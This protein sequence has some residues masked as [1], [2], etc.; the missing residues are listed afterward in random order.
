MAVTPPPA[1]VDEAA[2]RLGESVDPGWTAVRATVITAVRRTARRSWPVAADVGDLPGAGAGPVH[3]VDQVLRAALA[4]GVAADQACSVQWARLDVE[5][6][7]L[8]GV[9]LG[10]VAGYGPDLNAMSAEVR[11]SARRV[12]AD[13]LGPGE[14]V[15]V[16]VLVVD[17]T[18]G[19]PRAE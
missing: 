14:P 4:R 12:L 18:A 3:V 11:L 10:V 2:R 16:D 17:L 19:D 9:R 6:T 1:D 7:R 13:L 5:G 15:A 8:R